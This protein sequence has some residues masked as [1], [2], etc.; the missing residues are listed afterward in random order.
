M[1]SALYNPQLEGEPFFWRG[2]DTGILLFHGLTA[3]P[4]EVIPL[5]KFLHRHG[6]TV[7]G[8]LLPGHGTTPADLNRV[9]WQ[10]WA[11]TAETAHRQLAESCRTVVVGGESTGALLALYLAARHPEITAVLAYAPAIRLALRRRDVLKT[12]LAAPFISAV[13][14]PGLGGPGSD[15]WQGYPVNPLKGVIQLFKLQKVVR[16]MLGQITQP[17]LIVEG[18]NDK[19]ISLDSAEIIARNV[20]SRDVERYMMPASGH[21]VLLDSEREQVFSLTLKFLTRVLPP[22]G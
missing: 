3:T 14:K 13:P 22:S 9:R 19:T 6:Y 11:N 5:A 15:L 16:G 2:N 8:P 7:A 17:M 20:A 4:A 1:P 12:Y 10:D 18:A 21:V